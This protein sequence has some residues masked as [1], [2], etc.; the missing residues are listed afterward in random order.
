MKNR[1]R[2]RRKAAILL[3]SLDRRSADALLAQMSA[4]Q[5][6]AVREAVAELGEIDPYE[7]HEVLEE[8]FRIGPLVPDREPSGLELD[9]PATLQLSLST[10]AAAECAMPVARAVAAGEASPPAFQ[11]LQDAPI[12]TLSALLEREQPQTIAVVLSHLTPGRAAELLAGLPSALQAEV[13][14]RLVD[15][16]E[17]SV[18]VLRE[19]ERG[20]EAWLSEQS[21][22]GQRRSAGMA[23][24]K[25]ILSAT[26]P[27]TKENILA[28]VAAHDRQ[29]AAKLAPAAAH[30]APL[31]FADLV[32][33]DDPSLAK[34]LRAADRQVLVLA[35]TAG[36]DELVRRVLSGLAGREEKSLRYALDHLGTI[37]L[38]DVED[39]Q[40]ELAAI[41][42]LLESSGQIRRTP[43]R[44]SVAA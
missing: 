31:A 20:L 4:E 32:Q 36:G 40:Q 5:A 7:Q 33:L 17:T 26:D 29:L 12:K 25:E 38:S 43:R 44:L 34:V 14:R 37:R 42:Q 39:A 27:D 10:A 3:A 30:Q 15:L 13:A 8:F 28:N 1:H 41:A 6:D 22:R 16:D 18:E 11:L 35:L 21:L 23:A 24:L 9:D 2:G 19:V